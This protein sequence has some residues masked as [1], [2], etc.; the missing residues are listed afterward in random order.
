MNSLYFLV[1]EPVVLSKRRAKNSEAHS[2]KVE[3]VM[4]EVAPSLHSADVSMVIP[5]TITEKRLVRRTA[6]P[7]I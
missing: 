6:S 1:L 2:L 3:S 4:H 5:T 7:M